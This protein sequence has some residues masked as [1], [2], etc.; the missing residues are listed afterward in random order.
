MYAQLCRLLIAIL[1]YLIRRYNILLIESN[2]LNDNEARPVHLKTTSSPVV[3]G[4]QL[5]SLCMLQ[6]G[7]RYLLGQC[8]VLVQAR[9]SCMHT[10]YE[11]VQS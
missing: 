2:D 6:Q 4:A 5:S 9:K 11:L 7:S 8:L 1:L 10:Y 3:V